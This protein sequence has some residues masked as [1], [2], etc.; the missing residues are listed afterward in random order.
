MTFITVKLFGTLRRFSQP[1]APGL[2]RGEL[3][4]GST[5]QDLIVLLGAPDG[6]VSAAA[7]NGE[8]VPFETPLTDGDTVMLVTNVNG[9]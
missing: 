3:P 5:L 8:A 2:W 4:S 1:G 6:E 7:L 9:G